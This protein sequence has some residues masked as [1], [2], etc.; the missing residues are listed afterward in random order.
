MRRKNMK[1]F[2]LFLSLITVFLVNMCV[3]AGPTKNHYDLQ[4]V[5]SAWAVLKTSIHTHKDKNDIMIGYGGADI[6]RRSALVS[7][8]ATA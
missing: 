7:F 8:T 5:R 1:Q 4:S 2:L 6:S 3:F